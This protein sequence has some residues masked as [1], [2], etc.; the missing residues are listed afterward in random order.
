M[1]N[2]NSRVHT[3]HNL[4]FMAV[5]DEHIECL[6]KAGYRISEEDTPNLLPMISAGEEPE[7]VQ[8]IV[9]ETVKEL[10]ITENDIF[11]IS[12]IPDVGYYVIESLVA[13]TKDL[14]TPIIL[15]P[16]GRHIA[17]RF[18]VIGFRQVILSG[19]KERPI[20]FKLHPNEPPQRHKKP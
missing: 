7:T 2:D 18:R 12:G 19:M 20:H 15:V 17:G 11:I 4:G 16:L 8:F 9:N 14:F 13:F 5:S 10:D 1:N 6:R 3:V